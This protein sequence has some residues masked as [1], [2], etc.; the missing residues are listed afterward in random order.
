MSFWVGIVLSSALLIAAGL[1]LALVRLNRRLTVLRAELAEEPV[2]PPEQLS[3]ARIGI[4]ILNPFELAAREFPLAGAVARLAPKTIERIV[5]AKAAQ[6]VARQLEE[7]G[8]RAQVTH[9]VD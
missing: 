6:E 5:Y 8:V 4:E 9:Y 7:Q 3:G 2:A 1:L